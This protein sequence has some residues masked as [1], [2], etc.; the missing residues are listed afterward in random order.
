[1]KNKIYKT[2]AALMLAIPVATSFPSSAIASP[3]MPVY[4]VG[5]TP[6]WSYLN[7]IQGSLEVKDGT[8]YINTRASADGTD[9]N[10][11]KVTVNLQ[12]VSSNGSVKTIKTWTTTK[13]SFIASLTKEWAVDTSYSYQIVITADAYIDGTLVETASHTV[14]Q[15]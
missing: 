13:S 7:V 8:A 14:E 2:V 11:M 15:S 6:R 3:N 9:V 5:I 4:N 12:R 10:K 1:M